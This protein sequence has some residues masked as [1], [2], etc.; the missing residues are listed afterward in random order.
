RIARFEL[1]AINK[2]RVGTRER[3][4]GRFVEI[5]EQGEPTVFQRGSAVFVFPMEARDEVIDQLR[6]GCVLANDDE[7]GRYTNALFLP[8]LEGFAIVAVESLESGL[9][10]GGKF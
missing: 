8:Q 9:Q 1:L 5:A 3:I 10:A 7:T 2:Q 6:D 4:A